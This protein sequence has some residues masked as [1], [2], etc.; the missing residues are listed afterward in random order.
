V[1]VDDLSLASDDADV[2][3]RIAFEGLKFITRS[4]RP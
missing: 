2:R 3:R 4:A 1:L